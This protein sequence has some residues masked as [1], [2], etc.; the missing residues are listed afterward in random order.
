MVTPTNRANLS[1]CQLSLELH[2]VYVSFER[3]F[4]VKP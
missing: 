3:E 1:Y 2:T 4:W